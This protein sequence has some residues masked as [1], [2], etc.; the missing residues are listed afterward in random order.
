M[1]SDGSESHK[2]RHFLRNKEKVKFPRKTAIRSCVIRR[3]KFLFLSHYGQTANGINGTVSSRESDI[4]QVLK[5][6]H[7]F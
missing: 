3:R 4:T 1:T 6:F 7:Y 2:L 5:K